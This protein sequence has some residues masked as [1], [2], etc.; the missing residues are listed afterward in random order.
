MP[1]AAGVHG[2]RASGSRARDFKTCIEALLGLKLLR[3][4]A[5]RLE[6]DHASAVAFGR[7][8]VAL[9]VHV[10]SDACFHTPLATATPAEMGAD[11]ESDCLRLR[12]GAE[13]AAA[14]ADM[15]AAA[16]DNK[17]STQHMGGLRALGL[18][19]AVER[20][21]CISYKCRK[22]ASGDSGRD[23]RI[24]RLAAELCLQA[25]RAL[26]NL[27]YG[28]D[29]D[30][31]KVAA[32]EQC[33]PAILVGAIR[34][35]FDA[36]HRHTVNYAAMFRWKAHAL[37]NLAVRSEAMQHSIGIAGASLRWSTAYV[38]ICMLHDHL[39]RGARRLRTCSKTIRPTAAQLS[40]RARLRSAQTA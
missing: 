11:D 10:V 26:G 38:P 17:T 33:A 15:V 25:C 20:A 36:P 19:G 30:A 21:L 2:Y 27:C 8:G 1:L 3:S 14:L 12:C 7:N 39:S 37:R 18:R 16:G 23:A 6:K 31:I 32:A 29:V 22:S 35:Q 4:E 34:R 5:A 13:A 28:W 24:G 40:R 9:A